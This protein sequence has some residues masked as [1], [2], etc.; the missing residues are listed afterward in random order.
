MGDL[1]QGTVTDGMRR[2]APLFAPLREALIARSRTGQHWHADE[3]RWQVFEATARTPASAGVSAEVVV[4]TL[5]PT[6]SAR[7]PK[8]HFATVTG[9]VVSVDRYSAYKRLA[10]TELV[11]S[12]CWV[13]VRR[14]SSP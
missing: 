3:T 1:A 7:V 8:Q 9:G 5:D 14:D 10:D 4:F 13:H 12:F 6:R 11:L 2:L